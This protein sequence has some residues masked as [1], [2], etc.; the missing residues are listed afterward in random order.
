MN[1]TLG[2]ALVA[3]ALVT[4]YAG[5]GWRGLVLAA[6]VVAFWLLLQ[7]GRTLRVMRRAGRRPVGETPSAVMLQAQL[8][9]G[10]TM[11]EV[12]PLAGSLGRV[13]G[14]PADERYRWRDAGGA[15][16]RLSFRGGRLQ[17]WQL[18]R[19]EAGP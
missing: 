5:Y 11:L 13:D 12:L 18:E 1:P 9:E 7:L 6:T 8:R 10:M 19:D 3:L 16:V 4:G 2:W 17:A 14:A 15:S